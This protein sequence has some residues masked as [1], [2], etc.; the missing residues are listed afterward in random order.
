MARPHDG[1][2]KTGEKNIN[3]ITGDRLVTGYATDEY[4]EAYDK[5]KMDGTY[6]KHHVHSA[7]TCMRCDYAIEY[8]GGE[9][10]THFSERREQ[11]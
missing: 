6:C 9:V 4:R 7:M 5:V 11:A 3:P 8:E 2:R 1:T 10:A